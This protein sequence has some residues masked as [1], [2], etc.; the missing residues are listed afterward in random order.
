MS[1]RVRPQVQT[2]EMRFLRR[3]EGVTLSNKVRSFEV[4]KSLSI[5][6]LVLRIE[7]SQLRWFAHVSRMPQERLPKQ[8]LLAKANGRRPVG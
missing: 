7:R 8:A 5:E 6:A 4:R 2:S 3:I 1:K